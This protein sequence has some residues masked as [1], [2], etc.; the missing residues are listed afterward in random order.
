MGH[1][2]QSKSVGL[3]HQQQPS[4]ML[5]QMIHCTTEYSQ[6]VRTAAAIT[7][8]WIDSYCQM[9]AKDSSINNV[10]MQKAPHSLAYGITL[11]W[12]L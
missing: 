10:I 9:K 1:Y 7:N 12:R 6:D 3:C 2:A 11:L 4:A 8:Q 5:S